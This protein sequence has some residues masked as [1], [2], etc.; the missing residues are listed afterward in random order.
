MSTINLLQIG[1]T[2][3]ELIDTINAL[4]AA[5]NDG[6]NAAVTSYNDLTDKPTIN[7]VTLSGAKTTS[8]L[9]INIAGAADYATYE[10]AWATKTYVDNAD[11]NTVAAAEAAA[12]EVLDSKMD[13]DLGNIAAVTSVGDDSYIPIATD[14]GIKKILVTTVAAYARVKNESNVQIRTVISNP[15]QMFPLSG[16]KDGKNTTYTTSAEFTLGS[17]ELYLNGQ[18]LTLDSDYMEDSTTSVTLLTYAP[19]NEDI[20]TLYAIPAE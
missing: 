18:L 17:T 2:S 1:C 19:T 12:Q 20:L 9:G 10:A 8:T 16:E 14:D 11:T 4:V 5:H 6:E 15:R 7:G 13:K 3:Q